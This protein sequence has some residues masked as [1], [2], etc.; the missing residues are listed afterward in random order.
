MT[1]FIADRSFLL[2]IDLITNL[3]QL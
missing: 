1:V 3:L 2:F